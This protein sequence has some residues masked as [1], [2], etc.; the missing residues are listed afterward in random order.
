VDF[1]TGIEW[2]R[3]LYGLAFCGYMKRRKLFSRHSAAQVTTCHLRSRISPQ[4]G[5]SE[6]L[7]SPGWIDYRWENGLTQ[8]PVFAIPPWS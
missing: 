3:Q 7:I 5:D 6:L 4:G 2:R 8:L 1:A